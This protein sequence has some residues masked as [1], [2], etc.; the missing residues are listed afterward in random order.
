MVQINL[1]FGDLLS[2]TLQEFSNELT[3]NVFEGFV[4]SAYLKDKAQISVEGGRSVV[5]QVVVD[6]NKTIGWRS[7]KETAT[8]P[9][10]LETGTAAS[11]SAPLGGTT[12]QG[13]VTSLEFD[14]KQITGALGYNAMEVTKNRGRAALYK[15]IE[16]RLDNFQES[17]KQ[18]V[19]SALLGGAIGTGATGEGTKNLLG[20]N[21][22]APDGLSTILAT[23]QAAKA[24]R[25]SN[26]HGVPYSAT[27]ADIAWIQPYTKKLKA[28]TDI[29][30]DDIE[31]VITEVDRGGTDSADVIM[32]AAPQWRAVSKLIRAKEQFY[33]TS[34][35]DI[36]FRHFMVEGLPFFYFSKG[37]TGAA[38]TLATPWDVDWVAVLNTKYIKLVR[39]ATDW[40]EN[41]GW[42]QI[43]LAAE[44]QAMIRSVMTFV[45]T[46]RRYQAIISAN[47]ADY[48][49]TVA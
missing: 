24:G 31:E 39:H 30:I 15:M 5:E 13:Q 32:G 41:Y 47:N 4:L 11:S 26:Y 21:P 14:W 23:L 40:M 3:D 44:W 34:Q 45:C 49:G 27:A 38:P 18:S 46:G 28:S 25:L 42:Q 17:M 37:F 36:G 1:A 20:T 7:D 19:E 35:A 2:S 12:N 22:K 6:T 10:T 43:N 8:K 33:N 29:S 9:T 16:Q 48:P